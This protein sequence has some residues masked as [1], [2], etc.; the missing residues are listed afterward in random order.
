ML[1]QRFA[2]FLP[3]ALVACADAPPAP[4]S[5]TSVP[6]AERPTM[7]VGDR[8]ASSC[9]AGK[10]KTDVFTVITTVDAVSI[11][12]DVNGKRLILTPDLNELEGLRWSHRPAVQLYSFP[13]EVG[14]SWSGTDELTDEENTD[15]GFEKVR[16]TV[17]GYERVRVPAGE[18]DAF[19]LEVAADWS[20]K[21]VYSGKTLA[22]VWYAPAARGQVKLQISVQGEPDM[23]C[24]L[25]ALLLQ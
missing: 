17:A 24:E 10:K 19:R 4:A 13:L 18:F 21:Q 12:G 15:E 23:T 3:V 1:C 8:W 11:K 14:K 5:T 7:K 16:V 25:T 9:T 2:W 22:T 20:S 6:T